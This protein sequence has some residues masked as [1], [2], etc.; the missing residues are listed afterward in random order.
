MPTTE[1]YSQLKTGPLKRLYKYYTP[2]AVNIAGGVPMESC[3]PMKSVTVD[4]GSNTHIKCEGDTLFLNY[5]RGDG[6]P[7]LREWILSHV[8]DVHNSS[9][10]GGTVNTC[11]TIGSTDALLKILQLVHTDAIL[12]DEFAYGTAVA[13][14]G[15][16]GKKAVGVAMD[17]SGLI[18]AALEE[19]VN[20]LRKR[21]LAANLLYLVPTGQNPMGFS[22]PSAR[23]ME[24]LSMCQR[25]GVTII[26]DGELSSSR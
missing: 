12:M 14:A 16:T 6:V 21:G 15:A 11:M 18:P 26:E 24:I 20:S 9:P 4:I 7:P 10:S 22:I 17:D 5:L 3:F 2:D 23:R 8:S 13:V 19:A 25:M 1:L